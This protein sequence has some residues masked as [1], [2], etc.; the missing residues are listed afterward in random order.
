MAEA[1]LERMRKRVEEEDVS[2]IVLEVL[3]QFPEAKAEV[4]RRLE[5][6][7]DQRPRREME[8][9]ELAVMS[10]EELERRAREIIERRDR[11]R[12]EGKL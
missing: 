12:A 10:D 2:G 1:E 3:E 4:R 8:P 11:E 6:M 9:E 7:A 5:E